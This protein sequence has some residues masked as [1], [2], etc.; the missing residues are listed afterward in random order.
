MHLLLLHLLHLL[1][2]AVCDTSYSVTHIHD[3]VALKSV[4]LYH[5]V[6]YLLH[7][8]T[9]SDSQVGDDT[10]DSMRERLV[11]PLLILLPFDMCDA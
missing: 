8:V 5:V 3:P 10:V 1:R 2:L 4:L 6:S 7:A 9:S 11:Y